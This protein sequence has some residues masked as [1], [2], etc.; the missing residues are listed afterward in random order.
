[1]PHLP[2]GDV[3]NWVS[4]LGNLVVGSEAPKV[5][6][7]EALFKGRQGRERSSSRRRLGR[8]GV[9]KGYSC[10]TL[11]ASRLHHLPIR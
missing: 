11:P 10:S 9:R 8:G 5:S 3:A 6:P 2:A 7:D 4:A 1:M